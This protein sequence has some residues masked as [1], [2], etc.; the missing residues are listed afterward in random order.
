MLEGP[1]P[2]LGRSILESS[3]FRF[4][5]KRHGSFDGALRLVGSGGSSPD[6]GLLG[7]VV[8]T[9]SRSCRKDLKG[10][11]GS[12]RKRGAISLKGNK[13]EGSFVISTISDDGADDVCSGGSSGK[14]ARM[15][16]KR[17]LSSAKSHFWVSLSVLIM[18]SRAL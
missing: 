15:S 11:F 5:K 18:Q 3:S 10:L 2:A 12:W 16:R 17:S 7:P 9:S 14:V 8:L 4:P 6:R 13:S 1:Y